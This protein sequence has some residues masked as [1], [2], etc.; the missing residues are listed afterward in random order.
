MNALGHLRPAIFLDRDG[1]L[2]EDPGY[3]SRPEQVR[4]YPGAAQALRRFRRAGY[5]TIIV[6]NQS[7]IGRGY[8][9]V[10]DYEAVD[11]EFRQQL[12]ADR[13]EQLIDGTYFC[14][15]KPEDKSPRRKP[16][17]GMLL[18]AA[19]EN[20]ID[21]GRSWMIGDKLADVQAGQQAGCLGAI[22]VRTGQGWRWTGRAVFVANDLG[23][24]C[25]FI[26]AE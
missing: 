22:L 9:T 21:L 7:G 13:A 14:P 26:L 15:Q 10:A 16:A 3:V 5:L 4:V 2:M 8:Y 11:A 19:V 1:T 20:G 17:P 12:E 18:E 6:T 23:E 25:D 24:A